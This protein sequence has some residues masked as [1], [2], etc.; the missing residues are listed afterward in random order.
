[1]DTE[2]IKTYGDPVSLL[3]Q[4]F[5]FDGS[6]RRSGV[7]G[8][9][10]NHGLISGW[11]GLKNRERDW[12]RKNERKREGG[13]ESGCLPS[14]SVNLVGLTVWD[15]AVVAGKEGALVRE[16]MTNFQ[17][18]ILFWWRMSCARSC[19]TPFPA[20]HSAKQCRTPCALRSTCS[21][22]TSGSSSECMWCSNMKQCVDSNAYVASFPFGQCMEWCTMNTC[23]REWNLS[24]RCGSHFQLKNLMKKNKFEIK[25]NLVLWNKRYE[26]K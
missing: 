9:V 24:A 13:R 15:A 6:R 26:W 12:E 11:A 3:S 19:C 16:M 5:G 1:M 17:N 2:W 8:E 20:N 14:R 18:G 23:P 21:E 22:C 7:G 25:K 4:T 10:T